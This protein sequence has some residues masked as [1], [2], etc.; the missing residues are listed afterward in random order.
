M[1]LLK[2]KRIFG[3]LLNSDTHVD[4]GPSLFTMRMIIFGR[5][6]N[7]NIP[8]VVG[9]CP[10]AC[11]ITYIVGWHITNMFGQKKTLYQEACAHS[12]QE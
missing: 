4:M 5:T 9:V 7:L 12:S 3:F 10:K 6:F 11:R 1:L 8:R 2:Y